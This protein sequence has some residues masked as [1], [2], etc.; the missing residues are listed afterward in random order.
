[1][2]ILAWA[3]TYNIPYVIL[4]P[5]NNYGEGQYIEKLIPK[6]CKFVQLGR[7]LPLHSNGLSIRTWLHVKDTA[8]AVM[9]IIDSG[10]TNEIFNVSSHFELKNIDVC[11][12]ITDIYFPEVKDKNNFYDF[13]YQ[14]P[15]EDIRYS[16]D[17]SK[18]RLLGWKEEA[19]F[20]DEIEKIVM[21]YKNRFIW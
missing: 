4:R 6:C 5:T 13:S 14:R 8:R 3:R 2:L 7:K 16:L 12:K 20:E 11:N 21:Y 1:M 15:G 9:S 19:V 10:V 17:D 18:L